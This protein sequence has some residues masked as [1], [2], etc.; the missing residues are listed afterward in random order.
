MQKSLSDNKRI[1]KNTLFL[2]FRSILLIVI[3][4]YTT[5]E[6]LRVLGVD[7]YGIYQLVGGVVAMFAMLSGS[8]SSASQ[9]FITYLLPALHYILS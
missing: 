1:A 5:R 3:S 4:L 8:M 2:Y 7:N 9:R 6:I